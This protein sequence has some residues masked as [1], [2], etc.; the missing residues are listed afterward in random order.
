MP[1]Q[2]L[3]GRIALTCHRTSSPDLGSC[4]T[5]AKD[6]VCQRHGDI[7]LRLM[8]ILVRLRLFYV[9]LRRREWLFVVANGKNLGQEWPRCG[10]GRNPHHPASRP[11]SP[12]TTGEKGQDE[13]AFQSRAP[14]PATLLIL[15]HRS[16]ETQRVKVLSVISSSA[17]DKP[18]VPDLLS[19]ILRTYQAP[20][21]MRKKKDLRHGNYR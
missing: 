20:E 4:S 8:H 18:R 5:Q 2:S 6:D 3:Y 17:F 12:L 14:P 7:Y 15:N 16:T 1:E 19:L 13:S 9:A 21:L 11:P 10:R